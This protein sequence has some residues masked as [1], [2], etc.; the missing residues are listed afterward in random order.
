MVILGSRVAFASFKTTWSA[1]YAL[2]GCGYGTLLVLLLQ[3]TTLFI[4]LATV[5]RKK[6]LYLFISFMTSSP[7]PWLIVHK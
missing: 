7:K 1:Q 6:S 3:E 5:C 4:G 2:W